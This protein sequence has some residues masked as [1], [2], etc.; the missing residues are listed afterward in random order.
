MK[1][2]LFCVFERVGL[3]CKLGNKRGKIDMKIEFEVKDKL[4]P[5][6]GDIIGAIN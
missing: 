4:E 1:F 3:I 2:C 6:I 5:F